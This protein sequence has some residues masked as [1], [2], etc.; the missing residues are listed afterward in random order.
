[1]NLHILS[2]PVTD[3]WKCPK[4]GFKKM[5]FTAFFSSEFFRQTRTTIARRHTCG[6][7][8]NQLFPHYEDNFECRLHIKDTADCCYQRI[9]RRTYCHVLYCNVLCPTTSQLRIGTK[10]FVVVD[11]DH[12]I[13]IVVTKRL[14][15]LGKAHLKKKHI[16]A[17][18]S[19]GGGSDRI[20]TSLT[21]LAK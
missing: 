11:I 6:L 3:F 15:F 19:T 10:N 20:P 5:L 18:V 17:G 21:D 1:M 14:N 8:G 13:M 2:D 7:G 4:K 12:V 9:C 16:W